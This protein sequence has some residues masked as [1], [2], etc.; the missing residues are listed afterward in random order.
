MCTPLAEAVK[1]KKAYGNAILTLIPEGMK[2]KFRR[3]G[4]AVTSAAQ[5]MVAGFWSR[6]GANCSR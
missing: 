6:G 2:L 1:I 4:I 5:R 3:W